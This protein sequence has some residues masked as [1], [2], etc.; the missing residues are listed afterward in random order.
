MLETNALRECV[1]EFKD[2]A[3]NGERGMVIYGPPKQGVTTACRHIC[4][5]LESGGRALVLR[6]QALRSDDLPVR[7]QPDQL[8]RLM[9]PC[10]AIQNGFV[11][12]TRD[13][14]LRHV[15]VEAERLNTKH[16]FVAI[17][18]AE[19]LS[20]RQWEDLRTFVDSLRTERRLSCFCLIAGQ[21]ELLAVEDRMRR[22]LR[23][24]LITD[25]LLGPHRF[26]GARL[27]EL[28]GILSG[29]DSLRYPLPD[30]P[31]YTE[32]FCPGLWR[33]GLRLVQ[34]GD[35]MRQRFAK[36]LSGSGTGAQE[37]PM[38]YFAS[39]V[40]RF[41]YSAEEVAPQDMAMLAAFAARCVDKC[42]LGE[43]LATLGNPE[44][45]AR[46]FRRSRRLEW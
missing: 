10:E 8:W 21:S 17:D 37:L 13:V 43:A 35:P 44:L 24:S 33:R 36:I 6:A 5:G 2:R 46:A 11:R 26:R 29:Y 16:V 14:L 31:S 3:S 45:D 38:A 9:L 32:H 42:G 41:L 39:A 1:A 34:L 15:E 28:D 22:S 7:V 20:L 4:D 18:Q 25:F 30:G 23:H 12:S 19:N 40:R 27:E